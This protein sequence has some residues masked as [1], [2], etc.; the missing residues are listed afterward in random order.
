MAASLAVSQLA[1]AQSATPS[2]KAREVSVVAG[3][4]WLDARFPEIALDNTGCGGTDQLPSGV[5][6][7]WYQWQV[8]AYFPDS[9]YPYNHF[10]SVILF[11]GLP[12][13]VPLT[14]ARLDSAIAATPIT[15]D[16]ARGE[17]ALNRKQWT[18]K[19]AWARRERG[20]LHLR[21]EGAEA[22]QAFFRAR[23]DTVSMLWCQRDESVSAVE[24]RLRRQ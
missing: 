16:E 3:R 11:F 5:T 19:R 22:M 10:I 18:P 13:N 15:V 14:D 2:A 7:C 4:D 1:S 6:G 21:V 9:H 24:T 20:R 17:P 8:T 12:E 23:A